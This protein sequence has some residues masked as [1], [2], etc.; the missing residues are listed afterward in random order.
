MRKQDEIQIGETVYRYI[1][2]MGCV[3]SYTKI[4]EG[5]MQL[6]SGRVLSGSELRSFTRYYDSAELAYLAWYK[7]RRENL[8]KGADKHLQKYK[9][10][11]KE[12]ED[13]D[14]KFKELVLKYPEELI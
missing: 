12:V 4:R 7:V 14:E 6:A 8:N 3:E 5:A 9:E 1:E 11:M 13:L 2:S 10:R